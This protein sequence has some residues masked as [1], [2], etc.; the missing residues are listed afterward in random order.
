MA[1]LVTGVAG[2]IGSHAA[3]R[4]LDRGE[5]VIG[6]DN[7]N[8]YYDPR[9]KQARLARLQGR[10]GFTFHKIELSDSKLVVELFANHPEIDRVIHLAA[11]AGVR[12][13]LE[14][15]YAYIEANV[16]AQVCLLEAA[17]CL[18]V[19]KHFVYASSSSVYGGNSKLPF[20]I[21]DPVEHPVS[22]YAA[23]K[24]SGELIAHTYTHLYSLPTTGIR[25]FTVYGPW[26][27]PD[28]AAWLF[29]EA[30]LAGKPISVFNHGDMRRDFTYIDD[31]VAG[32]LAALDHPPIS[33]QQNQSEKPDLWRLYNI[34]NH[35]SESLLRFIEIL[36]Q[37]LG[38]KKAQMEYAP[39]QQGDVKETY[40]D[41]SD[42]IRDLGFEP[43]TTIDVGL[44][45]F[46]DWFR[47]YH[48][49]L[50]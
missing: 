44:V 22:L 19:L 25:F 23:T 15:P 24:R 28:M 35:R 16:M 14:N 34:G 12:Y 48:N 9:L 40:A 1:I 43:K 13:S 4:L 18:P 45:R 49:K 11:Q 8:D 37:A 32:L 31:A 39:M 21:T 29:A 46:A 50:Q 10:S 3:A 5:T 47:E 20:S 26:G 17:R 41:I 33:T 6:A 27:R 38:D 7:L 30:I 36:Q 2:F 42:S